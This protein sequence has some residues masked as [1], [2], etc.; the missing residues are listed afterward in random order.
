MNQKKEK[1]SN[2]SIDGNK[3]GSIKYCVDEEI[4]GLKENTFKCNGKIIRTDN[5]KTNNKTPEQK[6]KRTI[7]ASRKRKR[8]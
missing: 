4:Q 5:N 8:I 1:Q 6:Q 2:H 7:I 3:I